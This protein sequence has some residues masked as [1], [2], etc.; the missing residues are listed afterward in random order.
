MKTSA[1]G[2]TSSKQKK[3]LL[4]SLVAIGF[5]IGAFA[6]FA[7]GYDY[8]GRKDINTFEQCRDAGYPVQESFPER[9]V[10][11]DG[12]SFT[13]SMNQS[14]QDVTFEGRVVCLPHHNMDG[15][16]TL[17]CAI[18]LQTDE[19]IY[20]GLKSET[21]DTSLSATAG[22]D[23]RVRVTGTLKEEASD[24]YQSIGIITVTSYEFIN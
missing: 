22:S 21:S 19:G 14:S 4:W 24:T 3:A 11:P 23:K 20:Y 6:G 17:E 16:H 12:R 13:N 18:G 5:G 15:P 2:K 8:G 7:V 1:Q 10:L 9:C